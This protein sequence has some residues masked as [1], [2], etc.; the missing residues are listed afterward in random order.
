MGRTFARVFML[1]RPEH[2]TRRLPASGIRNITI[3]LVARFAR[4]TGYPTRRLPASNK[5]RRAGGEPALRLSRSYFVSFI[6]G[7]PKRSQERR[8]SRSC[9]ACFA[10]RTASPIVT[11]VG[12]KS[13][14]SS[15]LFIW[16]CGYGSVSVDD[17]QTATAPPF[18]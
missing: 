8:T 17:A 10:A 7:S 11:G 1:T 9:V 13:W 18:G 14:R 12:P 3:P 15:S 2:R 4:T 5:L 16:N 6:D